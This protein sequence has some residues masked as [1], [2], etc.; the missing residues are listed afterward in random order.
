M[1]RENLHSKVADWVL[2][3][4]NT[5]GRASAYDRMLMMYWVTVHLVEHSTAIHEAKRDGDSKPVPFWKEHNSE[6]HTMHQ[7][8]DVLAA[9]LG[10]PFYPVDRRAMEIARPWERTIRS[11]MTD[12]GGPVEARNT[13]GPL[14]S[15]SALV[16]GSQHPDA[17]SPSAAIPRWSSLPSGRI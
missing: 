9:H 11:D 10:F 5:T 15:T 7:K 4:G 17:G 2:D 14:N 1:P 12:E 6:C 8:L 13:A 3:L 16:S